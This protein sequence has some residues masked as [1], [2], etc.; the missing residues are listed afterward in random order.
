MFIG[1]IPVLFAVLAIVSGRRN[2]VVAR[3]LWSVC[4]ML[5]VCWTTFHGSHH[6]PDL[7]K[8]GAW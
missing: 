6:I 7:Q 3:A 1:F 5:V 2:V 8:L 4:A